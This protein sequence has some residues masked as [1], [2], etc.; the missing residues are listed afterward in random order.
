MTTLQWLLAPLF[1]HFL[2]MIY[3]A[4]RTGRARAEAVTR[5]ETKLGAIATDG[6][7]WPD[8]VKKISNNFNNQFELPPYWYLVSILVVLLAKT[9]VVFIILSWLFL[10]SRLVHTYIHTSSNFV[11]YRSLAYAAGFAVL[12]VMWAWLALRYFLLG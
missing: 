9:D 2:L 7:K 4:A 12:T 10:L 1:L 5:G 6:S 8:H 11:P 3:V